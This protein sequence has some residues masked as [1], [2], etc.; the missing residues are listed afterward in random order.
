MDVNLLRTIVTVVAFLLFIGI[1][2]WAYRPGSRQQFDEAACLPL[3][4]GE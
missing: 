4:E 2:L 1:V 3:H